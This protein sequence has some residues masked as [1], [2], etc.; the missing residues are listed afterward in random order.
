MNLNFNLHFTFNLII[1]DG[2]YC[3]ICIDDVLRCLELQPS[4]N[5]FLN[6]DQFHQ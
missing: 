4:F 1:K 5:V 6:L 2:L 3:Q